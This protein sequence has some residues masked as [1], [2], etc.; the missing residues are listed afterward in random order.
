[1]ISELSN[2]THCCFCSMQCGIELSRAEDTGALIVKPRQ[3]FPV[4]TGRLCQKGFNSIEHTIH[5]SRVMYPLQRSEGV[6][7]GSQTVNW[8]RMGWD[9]AYAHIS[10]QIKRL[11]HAHGDDAIA[12]YGGGSL[13]NEVSYLLGK[14]TRVALH[15]KFIDYNGRYCMS[16]A[17]AA[18]NQ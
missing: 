13:T 18:A 10:D 1:M 8:N 17:A 15:S 4:A 14:F 3:D 7:K 6:Q 16:S 12:V 11:Q 2:R 9:D 5:P